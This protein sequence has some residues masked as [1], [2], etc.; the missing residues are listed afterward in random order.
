MQYVKETNKA[1]G[2][3]PTDP[4]APW[5]LISEKMGSTRTRTQCRR[6]W[7]VPR[8]GLLQSALSAT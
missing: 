3:H 7:Y 8:F 2:R 4:E 6:K 1:L 5:D